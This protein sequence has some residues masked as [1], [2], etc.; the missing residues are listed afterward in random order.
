MSTIG[1]MATENNMIT[2]E[3]D[4]IERL[5]QGVVSLKNV[6][7]RLTQTPDDRLPKI[8]AGLLPRLL[9]RLEEH[10]DATFSATRSTSTSSSV[11]TATG[12]GACEQLLHRK[13]QSEI[14]GTLAHA[15][16]RIKGN[17][18]LP[19]DLWVDA[20]LK[21]VSSENAISSTWT[22][23]FLQVGLARCR[24]D[25]LPSGSMPALIKCVDALHSQLLLIQGAS[26]SLKS[27]LDRAS[28]LLLDAIAIAV[29]LTPLVDWDI[30]HFEKDVGWESSQKSEVWQDILPAGSCEAVNLDG[31]GV[32]NLLL[33]VLLYWPTNWDPHRIRDN[34]GISEHGEARLNHRQREGHPWSEMAQSYLRHLKLAALRCAVWSFF[35]GENSERALVLCILL[36]SHNSM[37]GRLA[38][39]FLNKNDASQRLTK[40]GTSFQVSSSGCSI[41]VV[42]S[43][44]ILIL[45]NAV[46]DPLLVAFAKEHDGRLWEGILG[47]RPMEQ[48][49]QRPPLSLPV[50]ARA[51]DFLRKHKCILPE[52]TAVV[53][54]VVGLMATLILF[55][56]EQHTEGKYWAIQLVQSCYRE[57]MGL[58]TLQD[59]AAF[60]KWTLEIVDKWLTVSLQVLTVVIE[61]GEM[62]VAQERRNPRAAL[63]L[64]VP[65][66]FNRRNDLNR[67]LNSHR[68]LLKRKKLGDDEAIHAREA[69]YRMI[70]DLARHSLSRKGDAF[71]LPN[72]LLKCVVYENEVLQLHALD[73]LDALLKQYKQG[74]SDGF[75]C[76][77]EDEPFANATDLLRHKAA[78]LLPSLLDAVCSDSNAAKSAAAKW[79]SQLLFFMDPQAACHLSAYLV[80]DSDPA[81]SRIARAVLLE[82][83][84]VSIN[85][86]LAK[87]T[88]TTYIDSSNSV[89][90]ASI[91]AMI[92]RRVGLISGNLDI[93][94]DV[95]RVLLYDFAFSVDAATDF[96]TTDQEATV[97]RCGLTAHLTRKKGLEEQELPSKVGFCGIC[98]ENLDSLLSCYC[99]H[100]FCRDCWGS[101]L[102]STFE[103]GFHD[104]ISTRCPHHGCN[105]R[106]TT[107]DVTNIAPD[108][109]SRW[110]RAY[111]ES[112]VEN[113]P[114][115]R[116]CPGPDCTIIAVFQPEKDSGHVVTCTKCD[117]SFCSNCGENP[118]LPAHC[119][120]Y[121]NWNKLFGSSS[122]WIKRNAKPC[123]N[124][125]CQVPIEKSTGCNHMTCEKCKT[126]FCW[127]CLTKLHVHS[128]AHACNRYD[129]GVDADDESERRAL[130]VT[131][132][133]KAH[134]EGE[135]FALD[136]AR[137]FASKPEKLVEMF[138]FLSEDHEE[139]Q[140]MVLETLVDARNFLKHSYVAAFGM[141][142]EPARLK[143]LE[144]HQATLELFTERLSQL[145][146]T[147]LHPLYLV[148]GEQHVT[149]HFR[150]MSFYQVSVAN[151]MERILTSK[152][153]R[154]L[155]S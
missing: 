119:G 44:L 31:A 62:N 113:D 135:K 100:A 58:T 95:A 132:R 73:A 15:L 111:L 48:S 125:S 51:I 152:S 33:D 126:Q 37:H 115:Y 92:E 13:T 56:A 97:E 127:L 59:G 60:D 6:R 82:G 54:E 118:H 49:L 11:P 8:L 104:V 22:F 69:A 7:N 46:A 36:A 140:R 109:L 101:Y 86:G 28:W 45:G 116:F 141:R 74:L 134:E 25:T 19:A 57:T 112:F 27:R 16:E 14:S 117:T 3:S 85:D 32:F 154:I 110:T 89:E 2:T 76:R 18:Y 40:N 70:V 150:A 34:T 138:W 142:N 68:T 10:T 1:S 50:A 103:G 79:I 146:E 122:F 81:I 107:N 84:P 93:P 151:Y 155:V 99:D 96:F 120:D 145:A 129:P 78:L 108:L 106:V 91:L 137:D 123:P 64:G 71:E 38:A 12:A 26:P 147:N 24:H 75:L 43:L 128:Q 4:T 105:E 53:K 77:I 23:A 90:V 55:L 149:T 5:T 72:I 133:Y 21:N 29:R 153:A 148:H 52:S 144:T 94:Q 66:P 143:R 136:Q 114:S 17:P 130:F 98:Y 139:I 9:S 83:D 61:V 42:C 121:A 30:D 41:S 35:Q 102:S 20:L 63:P 131:D 88:V 80:H 47:A 39:D 65:G 67:L 87:E 124:L